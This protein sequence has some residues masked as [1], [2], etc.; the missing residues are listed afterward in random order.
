MFDVSHTLCDAQ[1]LL[2]GL[3]L[4]LFDALHAGPA[5]PEAVRTKLGLHG[6][7]VSD[8]LGLLAHN[9]LLTRDGERY[10]NSPA[11][12][13]Y[14]VRGSASYVGD[15]VQR[16]VFPALSGLAES[17]RTGAPHG[18]DRFPDFTDAVDRPGLL[19]QFASQMDRLTDPLVPHLLTTYDGWRDHRLVLDVGGCR[20]TV[21]SHVLAAHPHLVGGVFDLPMM[22]PLFDEKAAERGLG[23]RMVFHAGDFFADPLPAADIVI[24]GHAL[25]DWRA[26]QRRS[27][28]GK[29]FDSLNAG[30]V[31]LVYDR[32]LGRGEAAAES[33]NL[34]VSLSMLVLTRHGAAYHVDE[35]RSHATAAG[36]A[37]VT[38]RPLGP[39]DTLAVCR[40]AR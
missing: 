20:G 26:E 8:W 33:H 2:A 32:M 31:L 17:L 18:G 36:F 15:V 40:K 27:L 10:V 14:L 11:A 3:E 6:R 13:A 19:R 24:I 12:E 7:G 35:L 23:E 38:H 30:G 25:V 21:L 28:V 22:A 5:D 1:A 34:K 39:Y 16:R 37:S 29:A 9:G 4:G